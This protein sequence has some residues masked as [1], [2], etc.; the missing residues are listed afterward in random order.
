MQIRGQILCI[1]TPEADSGGGGEWFFLLVSL[2][3]LPCSGK[4]LDISEK[5]CYS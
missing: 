4:F 2:H 1:L 3:F 5:M